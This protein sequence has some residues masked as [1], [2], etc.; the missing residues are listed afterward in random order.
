MR[1]LILLPLSLLALACKTDSGDKSNPSSTSTDGSGES[2]TDTDT[3]ADTDTGGEEPSDQDGDGQ[4]VAEGDC[5]DRDPSR[6]RGAPDADGDG[7]DTNCDGVD[8][9]RFVLAETLAIGRGRGDLPSEW[10]DNPGNTAGFVVR[11]TADAT[12]DG[13]PDYAVGGPSYFFDPEGPGRPQPSVWLLSGLSAGDLSLSEA[14]AAVWRVPEAEG[15]NDFGT[16]LDGAGDHDADGLSDLVIGAGQAYGEGWTGGIAA[17]YS[18]GAGGV[19]GADDYTF[20]VYGGDGDHGLGAVVTGGVD[21]DADGQMDVLA[22]VEDGAG[23]AATLIFTDPPH[24]RVAA[25][26]A[27]LRLEASV[28]PSAAAAWDVDGD[29]YDDLLLFDGADVGVAPGPFT[30]P[31]PAARLFTIRP[32]EGG[33]PAFS[34]G[35][36]NG[37]GSVDL[38]YGAAGEDSAGSNSG[39]VAFFL[40]PLGGTWGFDEADA[41][42]DAEQAN[43]GLSRGLSIAGDLDG[44]GDDEIVVGAP[45]VYVNRLGAVTLFWDLWEGTVTTAAADLVIDGAGLGDCFGWSLSTSGDL[46]GDG[47]DDL[48]V[49]APYDAQWAGV[50]WSLSGAD[51][52]GWAP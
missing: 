7:T 27:D 8:A 36:V 3:D 22:L 49:G 51:L 39:R 13:L 44:D 42:L 18:T 1:A 19:R 9:S 47:R 41:Y 2:D 6:Y 50:A 14:A 28:L 21:T 40:G 37:D 31:A 29:G 48:V 11:I 46:D 34:F 32:P 10:P 33:N 15:V 38:A 24:G 20:A 43:V 23:V 52:S 45:G 12:G 26:A 30:E 25:D 4:T 17:L 16:A 5:A 35:D